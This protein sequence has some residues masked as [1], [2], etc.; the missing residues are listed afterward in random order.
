MTDLPRHAAEPI[1]CQQYRAVLAVGEAILSHRDL[2][3]LFHDLAG[4]L[5]GAVRFDHLIL[6][7]HD[8]AQNMMRLHV[9]E[10]SEPTGPR[11]GMLVPVH[12]TPSGLVWQ[13]QQP[14]IIANV[15]EEE[16]WPRLRDD[17]YRPF[18]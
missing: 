1:S 11:P 12:E 5:H 6:V 18:G 14:V 8:D 13:S 3:A 7:L 15:E 10:T 2:Q 9:L 4:R 17:V 16:R